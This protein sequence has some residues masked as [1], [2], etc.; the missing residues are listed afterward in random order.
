M[1]L[2]QQFMGPIMIHMFLRPLAENLTALPVPDIDTLCDV[3]AD[4]FVRAVG[5]SPDGG[6]G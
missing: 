2:V 4:A 3:F 5:T 6:G 1:A